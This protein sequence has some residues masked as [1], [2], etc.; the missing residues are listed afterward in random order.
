VPAHWSGS[1]EELDYEGAWSEGQWLLW[2]L[3]VFPVVFAE[4]VV[5][6]F[7]LCLNYSPFRSCRRFIRPYSTRNRAKEILENNDS[8]LGSFALWPA[9]SGKPH[10][11]TMG[12]TMGKT[13]GTCPVISCSKK[14]MVFT[15][16]TMVLFQKIT[17]VFKP[18]WLVGAT[19]PSE[20]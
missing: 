6:Y 15:G 5:I 4:I 1:G 2:I 10:A 19:Y 3:N 11:K 17:M 16:I 12:K 14:S 13:H 9:E 20:K 7:I 8:F 18:I